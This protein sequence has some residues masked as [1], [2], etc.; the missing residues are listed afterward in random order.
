M[1]DLNKAYSWAIQTCNAPNIGYSQPYRNQQT[2]NGI[3]YYDCSSFIWYAL[4]AGGFDCV[5]A[6]GGV[7]WPFTTYTM[8]GVLQNLG[9]THYNSAEVEWLPGDVL[10][11]SGHTEM[12]YT[13]GQ[14]QGVCMGAHTGNAPLEYQVSIG[15]SSGNPDYV[16]TSSR[17]PDLWRY[18][19]GGAVG[20]GYSIYVISAIAGNWWQESGINPGVYESLQ[21]VDLKDNNVY[22]GYGLGQWTNAPQYGTYRRTAL[23]NWLDDNGYPYDSP[24]GQFEFLIEENVWYST[25]A[26]SM[27][28]DLQSF[29]N[30]DSTDLYELT[31][32]F[33]RGWEGIYTETQH[34]QRYEYAQ[35]V[36]E[37][38]Q[39][40]ANDTSISTWFNGNFYCTDEQKL[41][42]AVMLYRLISAGGG[43]GGTPGKEKKKMPLIFYLFL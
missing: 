30:S 5:G 43:G 34:Q 7:T 24:E 40:N 19:D 41:N 14:T 2:V 17:F 4:I 23:A 16:S 3:T 13:G 12:C 28:T 6:N 25:G 8:P 21:V 31:G 26:A 39:Q 35:R 10:L 22:G 20:Y 36:Y 15:S 37:F 9:F 32:A 1:P 42:N 38:I 27:Y 29:L 33:L 11:S 18:G